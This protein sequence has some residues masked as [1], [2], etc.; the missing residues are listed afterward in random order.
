IAQINNRYAI[1]RTHTFLP[2]FIY[3]LLSASWLPAYGNYIALIAASFVLLA[4]YITLGMYKEKGSVEQAFLVFFFL[5]LASLLINEFVILVLVFWIGFILL[6]SF[7]T[8]VFFASILGFLVP[9]IFWFAIPYFFFDKIVF[10]YDY[11]WV[12]IDLSVFDYR[13]IPAF[14][15]AGTMLAILIIAFVQIS[16][17]YRQLSIE[18]G[19]ILLFFRVLLISLLLFILLHFIGLPSYMPLLAIFYALVTAYVF[20]LLKNTFN[21]VVFMTLCVLNLVSASY[22][23][24]IQ[25]L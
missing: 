1:I 6:N 14:L 16:T 20:T 19:R 3:L 25:S 17:N 23:L 24:I 21:S 8:R 12:D 4:A 11:H 2:T 9:W 15:Y 10:L 22:L 5:G 18:A 13:N 7:S